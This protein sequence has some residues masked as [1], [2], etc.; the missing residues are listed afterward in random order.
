M[1]SGGL[2]KYYA[3]VFVIAF[4]VAVYN[5]Y[6]YDTHKKETCIRY[7]TVSIFQYAPF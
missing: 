6:V 3:F 5:L 7:E 1:A 2:M 4:F